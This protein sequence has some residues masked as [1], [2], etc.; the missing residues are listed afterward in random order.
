MKKRLSYPLPVRKKP[1]WAMFM[2]LCMFISIFSAVAAKADS[3]NRCLQF[4][5]NGYAQSSGKLIP[6]D[7]DFTVEMWVYSF[8]S[9]S[10]KFAEFISQNTQPFAFYMG[11]DPNGYLRMGD[12][13]MDTGVKLE[14]NVWTHVALTHTASDFLKLYVDGKQV[15]SK[16]A[17][18]SAYNTNGTNTRIGSYYWPAAGE[19]FSGCLDDIRI[20]NEVRTEKEIFDNK[21]ING[22]SKV[23]SNLI[24][25]YSFDF[26]T[27]IYNNVTKFYPDLAPSSLTGEQLFVS[28]GGNISAVVKGQIASTAI[29]SKCGIKNS[30]QSISK[31]QN[32]PTVASVNARDTRQTSL[33][34]KISGLPN[35]ACV[36]L[37]TFIV[38]TTEPLNTTVGVVSNV[39]SQGKTSKNR[40]ILDTS[41]FSC[42]GGPYSQTEVRAWWSYGGKFSQYGEPYLLPNC[43][44]SIPASASDVIAEMTSISLV[45]ENGKQA[46]WALQTALRLK[47]AGFS[48]AASR[49]SNIVTDT[50]RDLAGCH[51]QVKIAELQKIS[52]GI[53]VEIG[54]LDN[55][56]KVSN[57][58][59]VHPF[60]PA[61]SVSLPDTTVLRWRVSTGT[62][63]E[64]YSAPFIHVAGANATKGVNSENSN[65]TIQLETP[66]NLSVSAQGDELV[67]RVTLPIKTR[68][69]VSSIVLIS[70]GLGF[71]GSNPLFGSIESSFGIFR[72]PVSKLS[73]RTGVEKLFIE[74]RGKGVSTSKTLAGEINT[75]KYAP[76]S[77]PSPKQ[78]SKIKASA[79]PSIKASIKPSAKPTL[80]KTTLTPRPSASTVNAIKC[81]KGSIVRTF[82][83]AKCPPGW[84][85]S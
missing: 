12:I 70:E 29:E 34:L 39:D 80:S 78:S 16:N 73:G 38:G 52:N 40:M 36:G 17:G 26:L 46:T 4:Q 81:I 67:I 82:L 22:T 41:Q 20:W 24:A 37:D 50:V 2:A 18:R 31:Q 63:W 54:N 59:S 76:K 35:G 72:F 14:N 85:N 51:A 48:P 65:S 71:S 74:S 69:K 68:S 1:A 13:W 21:D 58:D 49:T 43:F 23:Q 10:G 45:G 55:W 77:T 61:K 15:G 28:Q 3:T 83:A 6:V 11:V 33:G 32:I 42:A 5:G 8:S 66:T 56:E 64:V 7:K 9:N 62:D 19:Y 57:C 30:S 25:A 44:G 27:A 53:W 75:L 84:K 79:S 47:E 60:R